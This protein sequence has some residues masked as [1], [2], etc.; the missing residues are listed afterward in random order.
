MALIRVLILHRSRLTREALATA[1]EKLG[2]FQATGA[3]LYESTQAHKDVTAL[4][5]NESPDVVM[6][7]LDFPFRTGLSGARCI[8][9][10]CPSTR[11]VLTGVPLVETEIMACIETGVAG[12][13]L[14]DASLH[15]L[16][17]II[18]AVH[19]GENRC[20][21]QITR[22]LFLAVSGRAQPRQNRPIQGDVRLTRRE[23]EVTE[24]IERGLCNK[25]IAV[26]L[27]IEL[28]TVKNHVHNVL[29]KLHLRGRRDA[30]RYARD[31]GLLG[32]S[33]DSGELGPES[34]ST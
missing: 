28:Q 31:R 20:S 11:I 5:R 10:D 23:L 6:L 33:N 12:C 4:V 13:E 30:A 18:K 34:T 26:Y 8:L 29:D 27:G 32:N 21:P 1:L 7:D 25:E 16:V 24:L 19:A 3:T 9:D 14:E 15:E 17:E 22:L 2:S